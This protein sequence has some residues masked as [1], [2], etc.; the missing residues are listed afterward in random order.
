VKDLTSSGSDPTRRYSDASA[1]RG[2]AILD[3]AS[4]AVMVFDPSDGARRSLSTLNAGSPVREGA[5][6]SRHSLT[7]DPQSASSEIDG[8]ASRSDAGLG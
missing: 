6:M 4:I 1:R 3:V 7:L 2:A 5:K 8:F